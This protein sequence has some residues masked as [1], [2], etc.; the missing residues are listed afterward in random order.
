MFLPEVLFQNAPICIRLDI[1]RKHP[2]HK[3]T[4]AYTMKSNLDLKILYIHPN[5][6][7]NH[8]YQLY[9]ARY[10][11]RIV[12]YIIHVVFKISSKAIICH[13]RNTDSKKN[14]DM[15]I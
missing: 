5:I 1:S 4:Y 12:V 13:Y 2:C 8:K 6:T 10:K 14:I 7:N 15:Y 3:C 11:Q 9:N